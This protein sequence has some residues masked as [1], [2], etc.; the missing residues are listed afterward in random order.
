M[1]PGLK[2]ALAPLGRWLADSATACLKPFEPVSVTVYVAVWPCCIDCDDGANDR[3]KSAVDELA[4]TSPLVP[5]TAMTTATATAT[6]APRNAKPFALA[7][8]ATLTSR[9]P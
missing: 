3:E 1:E 5:R 9:S 7:P 2:E 8:F 6:S 4:K